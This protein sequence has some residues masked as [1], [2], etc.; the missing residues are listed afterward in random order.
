MI[1]VGSR[2]KMFKNEPKVNLGNFLFLGI[3]D[4]RTGSVSDAGWKSESRLPSCGG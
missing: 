2:E 4:D 1:E 3:P